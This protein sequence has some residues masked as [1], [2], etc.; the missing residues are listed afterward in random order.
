MQRE[1]QHDL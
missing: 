1:G